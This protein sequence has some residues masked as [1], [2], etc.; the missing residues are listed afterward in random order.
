[1][2]DT[3]NIRSYFDLQLM[4]W[5]IILIASVQHFRYTNSIGFG[6]ELAQ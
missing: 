4:L 5:S 2:D 3:K 1:M 6:F